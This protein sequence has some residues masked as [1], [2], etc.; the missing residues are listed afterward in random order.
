MGRE[1][2]VVEMDEG[3]WKESQGEDDDFMMRR[4]MII[5]LKIMEG[6]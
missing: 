5:V 3:R 6:D 4:V 2:E 1:G